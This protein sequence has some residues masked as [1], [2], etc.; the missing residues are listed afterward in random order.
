MQYTVIIPCH[1]EAKRL[2]LAAF[3]R[4]EANHPEAALLF[5]DDGSTDATAACLADFPVLHLEENVGKAEAIRRGIIATLA[6]DASTE[7]FAFLDAD[8]ATGLD[9]LARLAGIL[10]EKPRLAMVIG[11]RWPHLGAHIRRGAVRALAGR[12]MAWMI[13]L[14]LGRPVYDTQCGAKVFRREVAWAL[15][16][17]PFHSRWL[18]DVELLLRLHGRVEE[19]PLRAWREVGGSKLGLG[20]MLRAPFELARIVWYASRE[21]ASR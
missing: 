5:V 12:L 15:F 6:L 8:L 9:E 3:R 14:A 18:F 21:G 10:A 2:N 11:S 7:A 13:R 16:G 17:R 1:N 4:F 20:A 19:V